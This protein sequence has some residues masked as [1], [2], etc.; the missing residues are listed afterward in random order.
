MKRILFL[1]CAIVFMVSAFPMMGVS[2]ATETVTALE[3]GYENVLFSNDYRGF[4]LDRDLH[5]AQNGNPFIVTDTEAATSNYDSR[6][7]AQELKV[8][9]T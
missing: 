2:A 1:L 3:T 5:G 4:C 6:V 7:I 8:L 9:F